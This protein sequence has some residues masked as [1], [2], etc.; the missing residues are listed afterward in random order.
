MKQRRKNGGDEQ[1][2]PCRFRAA[3]HDVHDALGSV[4]GLTDDSGNLVE[5][6]VYDQ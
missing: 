5:R 3:S 2:K 1:G 6:Y 4:I